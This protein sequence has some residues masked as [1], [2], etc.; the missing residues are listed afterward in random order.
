MAPA[1]FLA[2]ATSVLART[3][4]SLTMPAALLSASFRSWSAAG[5]AATCATGSSPW[6]SASRPA[7]TLQLDLV[8]Q[9]LG[10]LPDRR[11]LLLRLVH[12][13]RRLGRPS[14]SPNPPAVT[15]CSPPAAPPPRRLRRRGRDAATSVLTEG[16]RHRAA[17]L[18]AERDL[19]RGAE[20]DA[21]AAPPSTPGRRSPGSPRAPISERG[22]R[23]P[24]SYWS[25]WSSPLEPLH[26]H[27]GPAQLHV[28]R[29]HEEPAVLDLNC[30]RMAFSPGLSRN[31]SLV[32][33]AIFSSGGKSCSPRLRRL[34][35]ARRR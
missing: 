1:F 6:P 13:L 18:D 8:R 5:L 20:I 26:G 7:G 21:R 28:E 27:R 17:E 10:L 32:T 35:V 30:A 25:D 12:Q 9:R 4:A 29:L 15:C 11:R 34:D 3:S 23:R 2:S 22:T 33:S 14:A 19:G 16:F 24:R 31:W